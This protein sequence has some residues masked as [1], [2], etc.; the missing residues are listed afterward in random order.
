MFALY[1]W[2]RDTEV[3]RWNGGRPHDVSLQ[4]HADW[5]IEHMGP[6][7]F[8]GEVG[9]RVIGSL[10]LDRQADGSWEV[11]IV[12]DPRL[13]GRGYGT[14]MLRQAPRPPEGAVIAK[15]HRLNLPSVRAFAKAGY[16]PL[17]EDGPWLIYTLAAETGGAR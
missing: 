11:S 1:A 15:I 2:R 10:R 9:G 13:R 8:V 14:A 6:Y 17:R 12:L 16:R 4:E 3:V 7:H 5:L